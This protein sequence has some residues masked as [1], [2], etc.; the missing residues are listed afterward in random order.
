MKFTT[1]LMVAASLIV[2]AAQNVRADPV[3]VGDTSA[4]VVTNWTAPDGS[5][6][7]SGTFLLPPDIITGVFGRA[8]FA[9]AR[10][11]CQPCVG[12]DILNLSGSFELRG[13]TAQSGGAGYAVYGLGT[14][15]FHTGDVI[16]PDTDAAAAW[17][18]TTFVFDGTVSFY[19]VPGDVLMFQ[20]DVFGEG[21][22][23]AVLFPSADGRSR[24]FYQLLY[25]FGRETFDPNFPEPVPEPATVVLF[26]SGLAAMTRRAWRRT[27]AP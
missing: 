22:A 18:W 5:F 16:V 12:G 3:R 9:S 7:D 26:A 27:D 20:G 6:W 10:S 17:V 23:R 4:F 1:H 21:L 11:Q 14:L 24:E 2:A 25:E 8:I 15:N 19:K 13:P